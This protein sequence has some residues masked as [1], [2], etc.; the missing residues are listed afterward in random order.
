MAQAWESKKKKKTTFYF[1]C[2]RRSGHETLLLKLLYL[3]AMGWYSFAQPS[4]VFHTRE[5]QK[6]SSL[7]ILPLCAIYPP[8]LN[9]YFSLL[10]LLPT[11]V[12][13][14]AVEKRA[15]PEQLSIWMDTLKPANYNLKKTVLKSAQSNEN[16]GYHCVFCCWTKED[17]PQAGSQRGRHSKL[18]NKTR[19][20][21]K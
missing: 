21:N 4:C 11:S 20:K 8:T 17:C 9:S 16:P 13:M 14:L 5:N 18:H 10:C 12:P 7:G 6:P 15:A 1:T 19:L 3:R 2:C